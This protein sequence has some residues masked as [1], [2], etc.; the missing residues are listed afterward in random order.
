VEVKRVT[1]KGDVVLF[2]ECPVCQNRV[3]LVEGYPFAGAQAETQKV[4]HR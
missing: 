4:R 1:H 3:S 2:I